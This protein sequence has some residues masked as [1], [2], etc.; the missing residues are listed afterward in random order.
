MEAPK[1]D[2]TFLSE[3]CSIPG[4]ERIFHCIQ[5]GTCSGSCP[6]A[7]W[8]DHS[9][10]QLFAL[11]RAGLR[12]EVLAS[13]T[14]W[15]CASCYSC[16]VRCPKDIKITDVMY[17][18]KRLAMREKT[19]KPETK[20]ARIM[21]DSFVSFIRRYGR[22]SETNLMRNIY[23]KGAQPGKMIKDMPAGLKL[24]RL[25]RLPLFPK[26][27]SRKGRSQVQA[28]MQAA[29]ELSGGPPQNE[30]NDSARTT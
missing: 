25:G 29:D 20:T 9:P 6:T 26:R 2:K 19:A 7:S 10:R 24:L 17:G 16:Y 28:I 21:A 22:N 18:L 23:L 8:M 14:P 3:I 13:N 12:D 27:I 5:C 4:G 15:T 1:E 11:I 30:R